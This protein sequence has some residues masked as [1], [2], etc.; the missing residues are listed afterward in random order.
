MEQIQHTPPAFMKRYSAIINGE[1]KLDTV[2]KLKDF[3]QFA[4]EQ[5]KS[6]REMREYIAEL[7]IKASWE[8]DI[9]GV[10]VGWGSNNTDILSAYD[11]LEAAR[12]HWYEVDKM[13]KEEFSDQTWR[14]VGEL[15]DKIKV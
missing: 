9:P 2:A 7:A 14:I 10:I 1:E 11:Y 12:F 15:I 4:I 8:A 5:G 3:W 13:T 6:H